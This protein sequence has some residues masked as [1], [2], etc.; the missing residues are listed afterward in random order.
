M[1]RLMTSSKL[2]GWSEI[3]FNRSPFTRFVA[4]G[5]CFS[6]GFFGAFFRRAVIP[7]PDGWSSGAASGWAASS[8]SCDDRPENVGI[9]A[10]V[11]PERKLVQ[12]E[13]QMRLADLMERANDSPL[14]ER[15]ER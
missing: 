4:F 2:S 15:P 10:V 8:A 12:V 9:L 5:R 7:H 6:F 1:S 13:R 14:Q 11:I 3:G